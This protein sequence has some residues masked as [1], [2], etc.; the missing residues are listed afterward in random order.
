MTKE[1]FQF[2]R[3]LPDGRYEFFVDA[4]LLKNFSL[5]ER[6][7]YLHNVQNYRPK[8]DLAARPFAMTIGS[9]W[10]SVMEM[11]YDKLKTGTDITNDDIVSF[12]TEAWKKED[13]ASAAAAD[14]KRFEAFG[15]LPGAILM[16]KDYHDS[17]YLIDKSIWKVVAVEQGFGLK[18][19]VLVGETRRVVVYWVGKP[20]LVVIEQGRLV[21]VDHKTVTRIDSRTI[22]RY[23]PSTQM[24]GYC[25]ACESI[26]KALGIKARV[27]R[28]VVNICSRSRPVEKPKNGNK[29]PRFVRAYP[30]F[31]PEEIE[32]WRWDVISK[33]ERIAYNLEHKSWTWSETSC[34]NMYMRDCPMVQYCGV[35]PSAR[36]SVLRGCY[37]TGSPWQP[38]KVYEED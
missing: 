26:A 10:S 8:G 29:A 22:H 37:V 3:L 11:F 16:L 15:D 21:P 24:P 35:T 33:C 13:V 36:D 30:N 2:Y 18:R 5:C 28:C 31:T 14:P 25:F 20:D 38:Y 9:W 34:H 19:E 32:E 4:S 27:S 12:A 6:Y 17:Q 23:K 7:M 1:S